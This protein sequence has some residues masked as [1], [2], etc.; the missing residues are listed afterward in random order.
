[1]ESDNVFLFWTI[2]C[3]LH[4]LPPKKPENQ[5]FEKIKNASR[6]AIILNLCNKKHNQ[7]IMLTQIW[8]ATDISF[9]ILGHFLLFYP[10]TY[11]EI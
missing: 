6:D 10:T 3:A 5:N 2:C 11:P 4:P 9:F 8:N 1:M 7:M